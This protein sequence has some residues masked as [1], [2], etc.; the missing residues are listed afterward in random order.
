[1]A[2][3]TEQMRNLAE[4]ILKGHE[5]RR[6]F[7]GALREDARAMRRDASALRRDRRAWVGSLRKQVGAL[8][9]E[10]ADDRQGARRA[11]QEVASPGA[12]QPK[13]QISGQ[14]A[15]PAGRPKG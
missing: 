12:G 6:T 11:W 5:E 14:V 9:K 15:R 8:C 3:L 10:F 4:D 1:M 7:L 2:T 13:D